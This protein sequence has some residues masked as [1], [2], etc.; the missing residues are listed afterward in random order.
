MVLGWVCVLLASF[1]LGPS[2]LDKCTANACSSPQTDL[3]VHLLC[4][5]VLA[6]HYG[7]MQQRHPLLHT[8]RACQV[9][10][11]AALPALRH[12]TGPVLMQACH[13]SLLSG[14]S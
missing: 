13:L 11:A 2:C 9:A 7:L 14:M 3:A 12:H 10:L 1:A 5:A 4:H 8:R 6:E